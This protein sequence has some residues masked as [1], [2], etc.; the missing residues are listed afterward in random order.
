MPTSSQAIA[1]GSQTRVSADSSQAAGFAFLAT[2]I[3]SS[4]VLTV[5]A[6]QMT[7]VFSAFS[8]LLLSQV[9]GALFAGFT[10]GVVPVCKEFRALTMRKFLY[11]SLVASLAGVCGPMLWFLG[12]SST[13]AVNAGLFSRSEMLFLFLLSILFLG[14][15]MTKQKAIAAT[16]VLFG[17]VFVALRGFS[18]GLSL[19]AGDMLILAAGLSFA[20]GSLV[21][22]MRV[23]HAQPEL[24]VVMRGLIAAAVFCAA[25]PF[26]NVTLIQEFE[27]LTVELFVVMTLY[28]FVGRFLGIYSAYQ[29]IERL[30]VSTVSLFMTLSIVGGIAAATFYLGEQFELYQLIGGMII[31]MGVLLMN[32]HGI[33][34][35]DHEHKHHLKMGHGHHL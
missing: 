8:L 30:N 5:L 34:R 25:A 24:I 12:L 17:I 9:F 27:L 3:V 13:T 26:L 21:V 6:K 19:Y 33:H 7:T 11:L 16:M 10:F 18:I 23:P 32:H 14:E 28:G 2:A 15:K 4:S 35:S 29:S 31:V 22:K 1:I 20:L